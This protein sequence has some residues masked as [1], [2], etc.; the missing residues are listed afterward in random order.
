MPR[1]P[2]RLARRA[3]RVLFFPL[4]LDRPSTEH[5]LTVVESESTYRKMEFMPSVS[6]HE[7]QCEHCQKTADKGRELHAQMN[8]F[9][10]QLSKA[11]RRWYAGVES[12]RI[13]RNGARKIA[14]IT[15]LHE[16]T[17]RRAGKEVDNY[18]AGQLE[19]PHLRRPGR[20]TI[21]FQYRREEFLQH[22]HKRSN[23]K[24]DEIGR[25]PNSGASHP[26]S[27]KHH[28]D[29]LHEIGQSVRL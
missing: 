10:S 26:C 1:V 16:T 6:P 7:C 24:L 17:I 19:K 4:L 9:M 29:L 25:F 23:V 2:R 12:N 15:G 11:Q 22:Y 21:R 8:W 28:P 18:A 13:K 14:R 3:L 27:R 20:R 5:S